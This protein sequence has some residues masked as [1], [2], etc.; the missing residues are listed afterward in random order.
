M[1][2]KQINLFGTFATLED[3]NGEI[4]RAATL[5]SSD[6]GRE[7]FVESLIQK[8]EEEKLSDWIFRRLAKSLYYDRHVYDKLNEL[9][10]KEAAAG[11]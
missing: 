5:P 10:K 3:Q 9:A 6:E 11:N 2:E 1:K 8:P 4:I 7:D